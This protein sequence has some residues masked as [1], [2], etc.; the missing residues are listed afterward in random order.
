MI[1]LAGQIQNQAS[2][3]TNTFDSL[4]MLFSGTKAEN[5]ANLKLVLTGPGGLASTADTASGQVGDLMKKLLAFDATF[6]AAN[7]QLQDYTSSDS[8]IL[9]VAS[10]SVADLATTIA[11]TQDQAD[12]AYKL[13][14]DLTISA[15]SVSVGI[16]ILTGGLLLP[17]GAVAGTAL[18]IAAAKAKSSYNNL[19]DELTKYQ[20]QQTQKSQLVTDLTGLNGMMIKVAPAMN[21]FQASLSEIEGVWVN[22]NNN[23]RYIVNNYTV[24]QLGDLSWVMQAMQI[25]DAQKKWQAISDSSKMFV[26]GSLVTYTTQTFGEKLAA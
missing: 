9:G 24:D 23:L 20:A 22:I 10:Q 13:W 3:F 15:I 14:S 4:K 21:A 6:T 18:G 26:E 25:L 5:A 8:R 17:V 12:K 11:T 16:T 1:W 2:T 19:C 7:Q